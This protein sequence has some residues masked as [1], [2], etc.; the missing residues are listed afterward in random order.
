MGDVI[1]L[2]FDEYQGSDTRKKL[3]GMFVTDAVN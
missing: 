1:E 3:P 2:L